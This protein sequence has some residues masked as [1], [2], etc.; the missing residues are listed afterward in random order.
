MSERRG[1]VNGYKCERCEK[2]TIVLLL[3]DGTTPF[4]LK[5]LEC[6]GM[7]KSYCYAFPTSNMEDTPTLR[8]EIHRVFFRPSKDWIRNKAEFVEKF[9]EHCQRGGL[10]AGTIH[11]GLAN[12]ANVPLNQCQKFYESLEY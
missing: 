6:Q 10:V 7:A 8:I 5:C 11:E 1:Q 2:V 4:I 9:R 12:W 3:D